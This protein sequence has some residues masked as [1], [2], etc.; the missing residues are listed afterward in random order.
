[1]VIGLAPE[2]L[3]AF[4]TDAQTR[5]NPEDIVVAGIVII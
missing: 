1:M 3:N 4:R 5:R 2:S